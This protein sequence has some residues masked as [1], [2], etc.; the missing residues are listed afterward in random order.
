MT[1]KAGEVMGYLAYGHP[2]LDGNG[3]AIMVVH[4]ELA[5]RAGFSIDWAATGKAAY[6]DGADEGVGAAGERNPR[7]LSE[8]VY[9]PRDWP[10]KACSPRYARIGDRRQRQRT[11]Q[12]Q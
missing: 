7:R 1:A 6:L 9:R 2:F 3:R 10:R 8:T 5:Q 11:G 12:R 4:A